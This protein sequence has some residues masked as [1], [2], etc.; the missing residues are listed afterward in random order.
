M[1]EVKSIVEPT[2]NSSFRRSPDK[3]CLDATSCRKRRQDRVEIMRSKRLKLSGSSS[4]DSQSETSRIAS[5]LPSSQSSSSTPCFLTKEEIR[6]KKNRESAERSRLKKIG[7]IDDLTFRTCELLVQQQ[8]LKEENQRLRWAKADADY[9]SIAPSSVLVVPAAPYSNWCAPSSS[10]S[11]SPRL[12][13]YTSDAVSELSYDASDC[14]GSGRCSSDSF[15]PR[16]NSYSS[17]SS[18]SRFHSPDTTSSSPILAGMYPQYNYNY[19]AHYDSTFVGLPPTANEAVASS[20]GAE[21]FH[22][23]CNIGGYAAELATQYVGTYEG[24]TAATGGSSS[25]R[26]SVT[27]SDSTS[28]TITD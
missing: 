19:D 7:H 17:C 11:S 21:N 9:Y 15:S 20:D 12:C 13:G 2:V 3:V 16:S 18:S 8:D 23:N 4:D 24:A 26:N 5:S 14:D 22:S 1:I 28:S 25:S 6:R 10:S 27:S